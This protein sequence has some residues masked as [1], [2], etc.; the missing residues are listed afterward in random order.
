MTEEK[1]EIYSEERLNYGREHTITT[2]DRFQI[3][4]TDINNKMIPLEF[5][6][7]DNSSFPKTWVARPLITK[8]T[9]FINLTV[10]NNFGCDVHVDVHLNDAEKAAQT[11]PL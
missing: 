11:L 1:L 4:V 2:R 3:W 8:D 5:C 10:V 6:K 7:E 9:K